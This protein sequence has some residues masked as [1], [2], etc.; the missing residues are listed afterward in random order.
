[1]KSSKFNLSLITA[2]TLG[3]ALLPAQAQWSQTSG[4]GP[5]I[6]TDPANW[7][8]GVV[9]NLFTNAIQSGLTIT[10]TNDYILSGGVILG[11]PGSSN[12]T[13]QSDS[14]TPR[15][16]H[17]SLGNFLR[18]NANGGAITIGTTNNPLVL[19]LY[20]ATRTIGGSTPA[21]TSSG[22]ICTL[23]IYA[24][25]VDL[26]GGTNGVICGGGNTFAYLLNTNNSFLGPVAFPSLR[27]GG[28]ANIKPIGGGPSALGAPLDSTNGT[29]TVTDGASYGQLKYLGTG[30][31]SDRAF[32]WNV[33][34]NHTN[35]A[36][37]SDYA[38]VNAGAGLLKLSGQWTFPTN[39]TA[40]SE[41][42]VNASTAPIE[43]DGYIYGSGNPTNGI[44]TSLLFAG[45]NSTNHITLT[46][47][48]N[49]FRDFMVSNV[50]VAYKSIA[51]AGTPSSLGA[52]TNIVLG[53]GTG[54]WLGWVG[55]SGQGSSLQY[56]GPSGAT[57]TR[58]ITNSGGLSSFYW[59]LDNAGTNT[60]LTWSNNIAWNLPASVTG[61]DPRYLFIN[62]NNSATNVVLSWIPD[63]NV[64]VSGT[65]I[66]TIV[67]AA[68]P[69]GYTVNNGGVLQLLNPTN[70]FAGGV[71]VAYARTVQAMTL[72]DIGQPS[73]I[74]TGQNP[75]TVGSPSIQLTGIILGSTDSQRGG[76]LSYIGTNNAS[77]NQKITILGDATGNLCGGTIRNDSPNNSSL[78]LTDTGGWNLYSVMPFCLATLGGSARVTNTLDSYM[79]DVGP[80]IGS[81][82]VNGS[83]WRLTAN[84]TYSGT[85]MV[86]N[87]TLVLDGTIAA[88]LGLTVGASGV[89]AGT[90]TV[91][92]AVTVLANGTITAGDGAIGT[93]AV[94]GNLTNSGAMFM[95]LNIQ[96]G[97]NDQI[98]GV[99][100]LVYGGTL[101]VT[102][103]AGT[104]ASGNSFPLFA[105]TSYQGAFT[106]ISP[107]TPGSGLVWDLTGLT[108]NGT[109]KIAAGASNPPHVGGIAA[110]GSSVILSGT[111]GTAGANY[112]VVASTNVALPL[113][114]W[115]RLATNAF[116]AGGG[117]NITNVMNA[118][119]MFFRI[120]LP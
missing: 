50:V 70:T 17:L 103:L 27:G 44:Y 59:A 97:T 52:G 114:N 104:L 75:Y 49:D 112:Y 2:L 93:L 77:S 41:F 108:N 99:S 53:S 113:S 101:V 84:Q 9:T 67:A 7:Y 96:A 38:F 72:A 22:N 105:A 47:A 45:G 3:S 14:A 30:D 119:L 19:D 18:T 92:E 117:F 36:W 71:Q 25:I 91:N 13:M 106:S 40:N 62:P 57:F 21:T 107:A 12:L 10:F 83:A 63:A 48:T 61:F 69:A 120:E 11:V 95:K 15:T 68:N 80:G 90:G 4:T 116:D 34:A 55:G 42:V 23:N 37:G 94:N 102:N 58:N 85:T 29:I 8:G 115:T 24:Q 54:G 31:T 66:G 43:L 5:Y 82:V 88:G 89:L 100:A 86:A 60:T 74:G 78:H 46:G 35:M 33:T 51:P 32:V 64:V 109:L 16:L 73:S 28:F 1:M 6:Y 26:A 76:I 81:L 79:Q 65:P 39:H 111:G 56:I 87:A 110:S 118:P 98:V 20:N